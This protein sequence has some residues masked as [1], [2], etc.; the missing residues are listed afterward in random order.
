MLREIE[1]N[2]GVAPQGQLFGRNDNLALSQQ[3]DQVQGKLRFDCIGIKLAETF[4]K[5][6]ASLMSGRWPMAIKRARA[7]LSLIAPMRGNS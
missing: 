4:K 2:F 3:F 7:W 5:A 6:I 1:A